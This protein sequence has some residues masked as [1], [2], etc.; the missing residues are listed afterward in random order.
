[1]ET[2]EPIGSRTIARRPGQ[3]CRRRPSATSWPIWRTPASYAPHTSA[4]RL[5]TELGLR[6]YVDGLLEAGNVSE[7]DRARIDAECAGAGRS[8]KGC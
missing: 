7:A 1:M 8:M 5:P 6:L 4:G 2:G 3:I